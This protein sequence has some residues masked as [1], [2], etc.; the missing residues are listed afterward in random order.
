MRHHDVDTEHKKEIFCKGGFSMT[1]KNN[2]L[3]NKLNELHLYINEDEKKK[4]MDE[5]EKAEI[6]NSVMKKINYQKEHQNENADSINDADTNASAGNSRLQRKRGFI[7]KNKYAKA[8]AV[9]LG[10]A[11]A[12][13]TIT[14][15][16]RA[17]FMKTPIARYF[18]IEAMDDGAKKDKLQK[19]TEKMVQNLSVSDTVKGIKASIDQAFG[20]DYACYLSMNVTGFQKNKK[21]DDLSGNGTFGEIEPII[22]GT[23]NSIVQTS[24]Q[25]EGGK[26]DGSNNYLLTLGCEKM[27]GRHIT[28]KL[29]DFGYYNDKEK[30]IPVIKGTWTLDW[31]LSYSTDPKKFVVDKNIDIYGSKAV[32]NDISLTP[33]SASVSLTMLKENAAEMPEGVDPNNEL[34]V[35]FADGSRISSRFADSE[36]VYDNTTNISLNF[37]KIK[38]LDDIVSVTFAG[39]TYPIHPEKAPHKNIYTNKEMKFSLSF[40]DDMYKVLKAT[41]TKTYKDPDFKKKAQKVSFIMKKG[42]TTMPLCTIFRVKGM[43]SANDAQKINPSLI[44]AD[45]YDGYT[46]FLQYGEIV[47]K[48][49]SDAFA[50]LLNNEPYLLHLIT[51]IK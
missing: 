20:D 35:D 7:M 28:L 40:S 3:K 46:Y 24:I 34:Y 6:L 48:A 51:F 41:K 19:S 1:M 30:F 10:I 49:Q 12:G 38:D 18:G 33:I 25:N 11:I 4:S 17:I 23:D 43:L 45:Y 44:Y 2:D 9:V 50:D 32:W 21:Y 47:D 39:V 29:K 22:S 8:A 31:K 27:E 15:G 42:K 5:K 36:A 16:A 14:V 13:S 26:D 37:S